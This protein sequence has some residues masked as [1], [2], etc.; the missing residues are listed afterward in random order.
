MNVLFIVERNLFY[1]FYGPV[2]N[3][4][5]NEGHSVTLLHRRPNGPV[6]LKDQKLFYY[7]FLS[8]IPCFDKK[9]GSILTFQ[10]D[11]EI[12]TVAKENK[13]D[14]IFSLSSRA[15]YNLPEKI[16]SWCIL[17]HGIDSFEEKNVDADIF[18]L[19]SKGWLTDKFLNKANIGK[20]VEVGQ[21]YVEKNKMQRENILKK[22]NLNQTKKYLFFVPLPVNEGSAYSFLKGKIR[23]HFTNIMLKRKELQLLEFLST[24]LKKNNIEIIIKSRFKR[25]LSSDYYKWGHVFYDD[26]FYPST[27]N[28]LLYASEAAVINFMPGAVVTECL[29]LDKNYVFINYPALS[30]EVYAHS[31][32]YIEDIFLPFGK[33]TNVAD[34]NDYDAILNTIRNSFVFNHD[35][36]REYKSRTLGPENGVQLIYN[37]VTRA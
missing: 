8:Q 30:Q 11:H 33:T 4:F 18:F 26:E 3:K 6:N 7:P 24:E 17:Q 13:I 5:I 14:F 22:Y 20:F 19:Y 27:L 25:F 23:R 32:T 34:V 12:V 29:T 16:G 15:Q 10:E 31:D 28:E 36:A 21:Y 35:K 2:I 9:P 37:E 1:K